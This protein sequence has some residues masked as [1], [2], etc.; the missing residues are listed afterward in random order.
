MP[1]RLGPPWSKP[2]FERLVIVG[3]GLIGSSLAR[4]A[5]HLRLARTIV[6]VDREEGVL[7]RVRALDLADEVSD[8]L[9]S[10]ARGADHV[11]ICVPVGAYGG[12]AQT[13]APALQPGCI[14]SD[15]GSV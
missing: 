5:R 2:L 1:D 4:A 15:V 11:I 7:E 6:A 14:V 8:D 3:V 9:A 13:I 12:V 10:A